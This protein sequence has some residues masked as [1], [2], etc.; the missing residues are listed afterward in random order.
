MTIF[1]GL[2]AAT[3]PAKNTQASGFGAWG[4]WVILGL[5]FVV[6]YFVLYRPQRKRAQEAQD[7]LTS[8]NKGDEV[9]TIG[10]IH[11]TIR[12]LTEDTIVI[13]VDEGVRL[14]FSKSAIARTLTAHEDEDEELEAEEPEEA[15]EPEEEYEE[16]EE[17][18]EE[19]AEESE[20]PVETESEGP[21][22]PKGK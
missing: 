13:E 5:M 15:G 20:E 1:Y 11:G 17:D 7:M 21:K 14:T 4:L 3:A 12:K 8:L 18:G 19:P 16:Y 9:V 22:G 6:M 10:G 2:L